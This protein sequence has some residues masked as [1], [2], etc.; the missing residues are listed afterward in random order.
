MD[1]ITANAAVGRSVAATGPAYRLCTPTGVAIASMLGSPLAGAHLIARN[2]R[3]LGDA[4]RG[5]LVFALCAFTLVL[6]LAAGITAAL[7]LGFEYDMRI[8][9]MLTIALACAMGYLA[10][11]LQGNPVQTHLASGGKL[12]RL[13]VVGV[14]VLWAAISVGAFFGL[15]IALDR[16]ADAAMSMPSTCEVV[17][18][19]KATMEVRYEGIDVQQARALGQELL[20]TG[21]VLPG[22][23]G[24]VI[25]SKSKRG[26]V[27]S[28][29]LLDEAWDRP[30]VLDAM[31]DIVRQ[32]AP[33]VGGLP[34]RGR[35]TDTSNA[36]KVAFMVE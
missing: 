36:E 23:E 34:I 8:S 4:R 31:R 29:P 1:G 27:M 14:T 10:H 32:V 6:L 30:A 22:G 12:D 24:Q 28:F 19:G 7:T 2:F 18:D 5:R 25:L 35:L 9:G 20:A 21:M 3:R 13:G 33:T 15:I 26:T 17:S 11:R 16:V